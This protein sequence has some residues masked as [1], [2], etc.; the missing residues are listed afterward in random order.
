M[1]LLLIRLLAGMCVQETSQREAV[2]ELLGQCWKRTG[3]PVKSLGEEL[4]AFWA[5]TD[6]G[7]H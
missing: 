7:Q 6:N 3:W 4:Q 2:I 5:A 1:K